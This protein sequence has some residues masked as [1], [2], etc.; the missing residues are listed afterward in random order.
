MSWG[1]RRAG[2][3]GR[4]QPEPELRGAS[5]WGDGPSSP[6]PFCARGQWEQQ[7]EEYQLQ[8]PQWSARVEDRRAA[9]WPSGAKPVWSWQAQPL[10]GCLA[11]RG[12]PRGTGLGRARAGLPRTAIPDGLCAVPKEQG[13]WTLPRAE[14]QCE[15]AGWQQWSCPWGC[16]P[17]KCLFSGLGVWLLVREGVWAE[18]SSALLQQGFHPKLLTARPTEPHGGEARL[19]ALGVSG[20]APPRSGPQDCFTQSYNQQEFR[21]K[22]RC[23]HGQLPGVT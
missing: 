18:G 3:G 6:P 5:G 23:S 10:P 7:A 2:A 13:L 15:V 8:I 20:Q 4:G 11:S 1:I 22:P 9:R 19:P 12:D 21:A 16:D 17:N 14:L